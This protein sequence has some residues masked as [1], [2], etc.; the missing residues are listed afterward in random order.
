LI[1]DDVAEEIDRNHRELEGL[2]GRV[3]SFSVPYGSSAD[4][5][6]PLIEHLRRSGHEA[7]FLSESVANP[8]MLNQ[9]EV[10]RVS[11]RQDRPDRVF[12]EIEVM[13]RIRAVRNRLLGRRRVRGDVH[14]SDAQMRGWSLAENRD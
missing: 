9:F 5:T 7:A 8:R 14:S 4:L 10:D 2:G 12:F 11:L 13:P 1:R 3:R 6:P